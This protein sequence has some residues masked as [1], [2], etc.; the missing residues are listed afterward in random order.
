MVGELQRE[1]E[2]II[3]TK[4]ESEKHGIGLLNVYEIIEA[5]KGQYYITTDH[6]EYT[7]QMVFSL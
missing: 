7:F 3:S 1:E 2:R 6:Q 5:Y 4:D